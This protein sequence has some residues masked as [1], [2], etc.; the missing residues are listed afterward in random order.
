M[1]LLFLRI[2]GAAKAGELIYFGRKVFATLNFRPKAR[3]RERER[4]RQRDKDRIYRDFICF[5]FFRLT[6]LKLR[7]L[8]C[9][10]GSY[11]TRYRVTVRSFIE[12]NS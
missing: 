12:K 9:L 7:N 4:E 8:V 3:E 11:L 5:T 2:M 1:I 6:H 10:H